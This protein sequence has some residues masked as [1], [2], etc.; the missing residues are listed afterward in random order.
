MLMWCSPLQAC[1]T[2][3]CFPIA[4]G[5]PLTGCMVLA[6]RA[7][8]AGPGSHAGKGTAPAKPAPLG[9]GAFE[10]ELRALAAQQPVM[11]FMKAR[12]RFFVKG[13]RGS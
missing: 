6:G 7:V 2:R 4:H 10:Q 3:R 8:D 12:S 1:P 13:F 9:G 11:L 5:M